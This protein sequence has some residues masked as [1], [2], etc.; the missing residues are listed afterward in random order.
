MFSIIHKAD[1]HSNQLNKPFLCEQI[2]NVNIQH[3]HLIWNSAA[4]VCFFLN[5]FLHAWVHFYGVIQT[6]ICLVLNV[7]NLNFVTFTLH[8]A[9]IV[10]TAWWKFLWFQKC[11]WNFSFIT[12]ISTRLTQN[13]CPE[14]SLTS[15]FMKGLALNVTKGSSLS[16]SLNL[17][18]IS[19]P[20][21]DNRSHYLCSFKPS[22]ASVWHSDIFEISLAECEI[23]ALLWTP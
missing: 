5:A 2:Q 3:S 9:D 11:W 18:A 17:S 15:I 23:T 21:L 22:A 7:L 8:K 19:C 6:F 1:L 12:S 16:K 10:R 13:I 20:S 4:C 14:I